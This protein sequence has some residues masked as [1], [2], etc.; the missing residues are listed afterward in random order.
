[1]ARTTRMYRSSWLVLAAVGLLTPQALI[2]QEY[3]SKSIR[4]I[5][6][7]PPGGT[8]DF[9]ARLIGQKLT[10]TW[11][12]PVLIDN[13][14]GA[15][16]NIGTEMAV[17]A[18]AD[19]YTLLLV[20]NAL[21]IN[22]GLYSNLTCDAERD[23]SPVT[24]ILSQPTV[25]AV[26]P[27]LPV[28]TV[29]ELIALGRSQPGALN[30][31]SG[32]AGN[33][34]HLAAELFGRMSGVKVTHVPYKGM[35][36]GIAALLTG[37]VHLTFASLVSVSPYIN[38]GRLRVLA[39]TTLE[40]VPALGN[41][42]TVSEAG[43]PGFESNSWVGVLVPAKT[44]RTIVTKLNQEI[45]RILKTPEVN[46]QISKVGAEV[47]ANSPEQFAKMIRDD[48]KRYGELTKAIG[49]RLD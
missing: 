41:V 4:W 46:Q 44:P 31:A 3:P 45:V 13:R 38:T 35:S 12:Q 5:V 42:P 14:G 30:Y 33:S 2:A 49:I 34:N 23:L 9:T 11:K 47:L 37:E 43:V 19:G 8:S 17:K 6:P 27:S 22:Q 39:V 15:N 36:L 32:G 21:T 24:A 40:R 16:G 7:Y 28:K 1:M 26:H 48:I 25:L 10:D 29:K 18:P 20:A